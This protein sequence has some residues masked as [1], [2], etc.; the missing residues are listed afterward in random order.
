MINPALKIYHNT[1]YSHNSENGNQ[2]RHSEN[3][4]AAMAKVGQVQVYI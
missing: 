4:E 1:T 2:R 3:D